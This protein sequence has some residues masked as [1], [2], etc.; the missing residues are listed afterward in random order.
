M[1]KEYH[2]PT[3]EN[4]C[5]IITSFNPDQGF[6]QRILDVAKKVAK[7]IIIDN[8]SSSIIK[9]EIK[10]IFKIETNIQII[11]NNCNYGI[12]KAL[13][14][15]IIKAKQEGFEFVFLLDQ[16]SI[17]SEKIIDILTGIYLNFQ[18]NDKIGLIGAGYTNSKTEK[19]D[20]NKS[21]YLFVNHLI[22]SGS[23][24]PVTL[25]EHIGLFKEE[26]FIDFVD[27]EF[28][29]RAKLNGYK[30]V[31]SKAQLMFHSIGNQSFHKFPWKTTG[32]S[33]HLPFRRYY[34]CR[35]NILVAKE[36]FRPFPLW[37]I[38]SVLNRLKTIILMLLFEDRKLI[39]LKFTILGFIDG[40]CGKTDRII[41]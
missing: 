4:I 25:F 31:Q 17:V 26:Y 33:N 3:K 32:T 16:D 30:I 39:K 13:N 18:E 9:N 21:L 22:T 5:A 20:D 28:C 41:I 1:H 24:I 29:L 2:F 34:M 12:A 36:Y 6:Y 10:D 7:T 11:F 37:V 38:N 40:L 8:H 15:G 23:L 27:I 35:N 19:I 14:Q